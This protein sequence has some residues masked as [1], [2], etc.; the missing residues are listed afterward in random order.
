MSYRNP[1]FFNYNPLAGVQAAQE[2][3]DKIFGSAADYFEEKRKNREDY[4]NDVDVASNK[5]RTITANLKNMG[6]NV[7]NVINEG[8]DGFMQDALRTTDDEGNL[9][10]RAYRKGE[11]DQAT[12][13][14]SN[15]I[16]PFNTFF[17]LVPTIDYESGLHKSASSSYRQYAALIEQARSGLPAD[18]F[19]MDQDG[20]K[21]NFS[22]TIANPD[23][24]FDPDAPDTITIDADRLNQ[25]I[26]ENN[27]ELLNQYR[28]RYDERFADIKGTITTK[29]GV[30]KASFTKEQ[31][32]LFNTGV[33]AG[34]KLFDANEYVRSVV[35]ESVDLLKDTSRDGERT[36]VDDIYA[37]DVDY[38]T[39]EMFRLLS[40]EKYITEGDGNV[41]ASIY[42]D[43][44]RSGDVEG[45]ELIEDLLQTNYK[46]GSLNKKILNKLNITEE[47]HRQV[48]KDLNAFK[49]DVVKE[50]LYD[51]MIGEGVASHWQAG[52]KQPEKEIVKPTKP[53][54]SE[55]ASNKLINNAIGNFN[56][57]AAFG[58]KTNLTARSLGEG[59]ASVKPESLLGTDYDYYGIEEE[60]LND[61]YDI[62]EGTD[63]ITKDGKKRIDK[64]NYDKYTKQLNFKYDQK[65][66]IKE[67]VDVQN[68][69]GETVTEER[70]GDLPDNTQNYDLSKP[71]DFK[72][73]YMD[74]GTNISSSKSVEYENAYDQFEMNYAKS[75]LYRFILDT[76]TTGGDIHKP[77]PDSKFGDGSMHRWV[78][79][80]AEKDPK[81]FTAAIE[82]TITKDPALYNKLK[83]QYVK[84]GGRTLTV[85][86]L[87]VEFQNKNL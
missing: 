56:D 65:R 22:V 49:D 60:Q 68:E 70:F 59:V 48:I 23:K 3:F 75:N 11:L 27:P 25:L 62:F 64:V 79:I 67:K 7:Q 32:E 8:I 28:T 83:D 2:S 58:A 24:N 51:E 61:A 9:I 34:G 44:E 10:N 20:S 43:L 19:K 35:N 54:A 13:N 21:F 30:D 73:L 77:T 84:F 45:L 6:L 46:D 85:K 72:K 26:A 87:L 33:D 71:L 81:F 52:K 76:G 14:F 1:K 36:L 38:G 31:E 69:K 37:N 53:T 47:T 29:L 4:V 41:F 86:A 16:T 17:G 78:S 39:D 5:A 74:R 82:N 42:R 15:A 40:D 18:A 66:G 80:V 55:V 50:Y 12:T 57:A 63:I